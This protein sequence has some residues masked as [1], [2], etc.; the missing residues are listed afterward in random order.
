MYLYTP[1]H[2]SHISRDYAVSKGP[3]IRALDKSSGPRRIMQTAN[4][5]EARLQD[6]ESRADRGGCDVLSSA[7]RRESPADS[8]VEG[9]SQR[10]TCRWAG[11]PA[12][13]APAGAGDSAPIS[14]SDSSSDSGYPQAFISDGREP[15]PLQHAVGELPLPQNRFSSD[16]HRFSEPVLRFCLEYGEV[17]H[18]RCHQVICCTTLP[19]PPPPAEIMRDPDLN[20]VP[21][22]SPPPPHAELHAEV[23]ADPSLFIRCHCICR[24]ARAAAPPPPRPAALPASSLLVSRSHQFGLPVTTPPDCIVVKQ[25][26]ALDL[27]SS[28]TFQ[29]LSTTPRLS[30]VVAAGMYRHARR[31]PTTSLTQV[32]SACDA[33]G[34]CCLQC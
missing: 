11:A 15:V 32:R 22:S 16:H 2:P 26:L 23:P 30:D 20:L 10:N 21:R 12:S 31:S 8:N 19:P 9:P 25:G 34:L 5:T 13:P 28:E 33:E 6:E 3:S 27:V 7:C 18:M 1:G 4:P 29:H 14:R 24:A 17:Q